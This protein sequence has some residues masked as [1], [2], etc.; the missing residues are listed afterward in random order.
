MEYR[1]DHGA[2]AGTRSMNPLDADAPAIWPPPQGPESV[3]P[4]AEYFPQNQLCT[5]LPNAQD[6]GRSCQRGSQASGKPREVPKRL[7]STNQ[8]RCPG[9]LIF[10]HAAERRPGR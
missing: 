3:R 7:F 8:V 2:A 5:P 9:G 10:R 6:P 4:K 1:Q